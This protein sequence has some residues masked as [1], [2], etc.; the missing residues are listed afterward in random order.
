MQLPSSMTKT[1]TRRWI[2]HCSCPKKAGAY[3]AIPRLQWE[4][5]SLKVRRFW[6][7][8]LI[9]CFRLRLSTCCDYGPCL[10][11]QLCTWVNIVK[12]DL[13]LHGTYWFNMVQLLWPNDDVVSC[14]KNALRIVPLD[15]IS[16]GPANYMQPAPHTCLCTMRFT[17]R[18][19]QGFSIE[20][21]G[22][23]VRERRRG[24]GVT[25]A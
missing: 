5:R 11:S 6:L 20:N 3:R 18:G 4:N 16:D 22:R 1:P 13:H 25:T 17:E 21:R 15:D 2:C 14:L 23:P 10:I 19:R 9:W 12:A 8:M 24:H 7:A